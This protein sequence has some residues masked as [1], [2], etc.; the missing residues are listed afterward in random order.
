[1]PRCF[2]PPLP[3]FGRPSTSKASSDE[4][5]S[6]IGE[7]SVKSSSEHSGDDE[8]AGSA[9]SA[10]GIKRPRRMP[11]SRVDSSEA[12][13]SDDGSGRDGDSSGGDDDSSDG[14]RRLAGLVL[15]LELR[16]RRP[17]RL[18]KPAGLARLA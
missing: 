16:R 3:Y 2:S 17:M 6:N 10:V 11:V 18:G 9:S 4:D 8:R 7:E 1:M 15:V 5:P 12:E 13:V 14:Q